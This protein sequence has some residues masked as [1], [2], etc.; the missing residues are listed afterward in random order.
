MSTIKAINI[1]HPS[2]ANAAIVLDANSGLT[3]SGNVTLSNTTIS[4]TITFANTVTFSGNATFVQ[5]TTFSN[6]VT[7]NAFAYNTSSGTVTLNKP[8][9]RQTVISGPNSSGL[10]NF[11]PATSASLS[12]TSQNIS[13]GTSA[14]VIGASQGITSLGT[15]DIIGYYT[16]NLTWSSLTGS[17]T[18]FLY[19]NASTGATGFTTLAPIYQLGGTP[20]TTSGQF[21]F[22]IS[23]MTGYLGNGSTAP[24]TPIVFVG[25]AVT[26]VSTVT[27]TVA[28]AYNG[29][30]D[31][32]YTN[33]LP[34]GGSTVT[35][36]TNIGTTDYNVTSYIKCLTAENNYSVNDVLTPWVSGYSTAEYPVIAAIRRNSFYIY[37]GS[38]S[39]GN[40]MNSS[41]TNS[42]PTNSNWAYRF[43]AKRNW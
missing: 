36:N 15:Q 19:I 22:N 4:N 42:N 11:L 14:L 37:I 31:S 30:Y 28:Y 12:I 27:S 2:A 34:S 13:T 8:G 25:E 40:M 26:G 16:T 20:S 24:A 21:T 6:T 17:T 5:N 23:E 39:T 41:G 10:P 43:T 33:T 7:A 38:G 9:V 3:F 1:Q 32:G 29:Y 18:C 35:R